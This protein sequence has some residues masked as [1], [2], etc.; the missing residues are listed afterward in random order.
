MTEFLATSDAAAE[1]QGADAKRAG[2][3]GVFVLGAKAF[4]IVTGLVQ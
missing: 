4:F 3:G 1:A 2:R